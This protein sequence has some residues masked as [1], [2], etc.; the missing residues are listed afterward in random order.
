[1]R[2]SL[3]HIFFT[4]KYGILGSINSENIKVV[5]ADVNTIKQNVFS[6]SEKD[7]ANYNLFI[8]NYYGT[9]LALM[10]DTINEFTFG[11]KQIDEA[12]GF[13]PVSYTHLD[14]YKRQIQNISKV[15]FQE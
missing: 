9:E 7:V 6:L 5:N 15:F 3:I 14:V 12:T 8:R 13:E 1:M 2:L 10:K 4:F 11:Q